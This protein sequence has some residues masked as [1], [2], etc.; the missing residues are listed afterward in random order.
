MSGTQHAR[1]AGG[2][3]RD[4]TPSG[5]GPPSWAAAAL[6][7]SLHDGFFVCDEAGS[8][9]Q[10]NAA[11]TQILGFGPDGLP[12]PAEHPWW[13]PE[14][15]DPDGHRQAAEAADQLRRDGGGRCTAPAR[16]R[17]G[18]RVWVAASV[19]EVRDPVSGHPGRGGHHPGH[20]RGA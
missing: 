19:G 5:S 9:V 11:F 1:S 4:R 10:I 15:T 16:H 12:Y 3:Q 7:D 2:E 18:R 20:H 17:D 6:L 14:D 8:V 13:P